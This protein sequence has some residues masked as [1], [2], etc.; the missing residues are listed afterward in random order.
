MQ[1]AEP[2][3][4]PGRGREGDG[5]RGS[6]ESSGDQANERP[7]SGGALKAVSDR[8]VPR[9]PYFDFRGTFAPFLRAWDSPMA[10]ACLRLRTRSPVPL[11][12]RA[13]LAPV[14][15]GLD[16]FLCSAAVSGHDRPGRVMG[17]VPVAALLE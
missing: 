16:R 1:P 5:E 6:R 17:H 15:R 10:I 8:R 12:Q 2:R 13:G 3:S 14:H 4:R 11:V 9:L 7:G